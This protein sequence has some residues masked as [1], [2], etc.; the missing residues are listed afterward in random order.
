MG[1]ITSIQNEQVDYKFLGIYSRNREEWAIVDIACMSCSVTIV[2]FFDSLGPI[3]LSFVL[4]ET[5]L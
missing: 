5:E 4:N 1:L 3:A 2:P